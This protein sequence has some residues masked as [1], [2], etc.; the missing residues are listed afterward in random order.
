MKNLFYLLFALLIV[1][2]GGNEKES[3]SVVP[4]A[5][6]KVEDKT[7][8]VIKEEASPYSNPRLIYGSNFGL[9]F[10]AMYRTMEFED[11]LKFTAKESID[12]HGE[13]KVFEFYQTMNF[14]YN[15]KAIGVKEQ[16]NS[17]F[18]LRY[19]VYKNATRQYKSM[20]VRVE[21]DTCKVVLPDNLKDFM[22]GKEVLVKRK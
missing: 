14:G 9:F 21:N 17:T 12:K 8:E 7:K 4:T 19:E 22:S 18:V 16:S 6:E 11:M 1:S 5:S 10:Q 3:Y 2:S 20:K 13:D 15:M